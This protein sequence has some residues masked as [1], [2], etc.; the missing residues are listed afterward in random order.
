[1]KDWTVVYTAAFPAD[2]EM[3]K[4]LLEAGGITVFLKDELSAQVFGFSTAL[5]GVKL[6]V[7]PTD[8]LRAAE[9]LTAGGYNGHGDGEQPAVEE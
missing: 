8:A 4:S 2:A 9:I 7:H 1:M 6:L 3:V 5:G